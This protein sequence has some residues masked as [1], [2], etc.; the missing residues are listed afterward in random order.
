MQEEFYGEF[1][2]ENYGN[3]ARI[4]GEELMLWLKRAAAEL[5][6]LTLGRAEKI[7]DDKVAICICE[8]AEYM[9]DSEKRSH[10]ESEN[11]DGYSVKY[12]SGDTKITEI[13]KR[14]LSGSGLLYRGDDV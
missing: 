6:R 9:Y 12:K 13:A 5:S 2:D 14:Y 10:I 1:Y 11:N 3:S 7:R 4:P 8:L